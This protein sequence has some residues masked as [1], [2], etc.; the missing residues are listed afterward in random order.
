MSRRVDWERQMAK[1]E[2]RS[3]PTSKKLDRTKVD[4]RE[5]DDSLNCGTCS[6]R[7][8]EDACLL[9][10]GEIERRFWCRQWTEE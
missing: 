5:G 1:A 3:T 10:A 2:L 4:Y 8:G 6:H 7:R 9:V